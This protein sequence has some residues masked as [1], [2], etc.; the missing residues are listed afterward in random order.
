MGET[1]DRRKKAKSKESTDCD[2]YH[3][4][5]HNHDDNYFSSTKSTIFRSGSALYRKDEI[6]TFEIQTLDF[7]VQLYRV[8]ATKLQGIR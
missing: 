5:H 7:S 1:V 6:S 4:Q 8:A 2:D 3:F